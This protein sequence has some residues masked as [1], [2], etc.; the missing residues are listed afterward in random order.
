M[1]SPN[2]S[3][4]SGPVAY[5]QGGRCFMCRRGPQPVVTIFAGSTTSS[6]VCRR[7]IETKMIGLIEEMSVLLKL[8]RTGR[9]LAAPPPLSEYWLERRD[10]EEI[11]G[12][13][14]GARFEGDRVG[15]DTIQ[16]FAPLDEGALLSLV[17][18]EWESEW[19]DRD[20]A[21]GR[22]RIRRVLPSQ[23]FATRRYWVETPEDVVD[24]VTWL[25]YQV[26]QPG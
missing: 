18:M 13:A 11:V 6:A 20:P 21:T 5:Q 14:R 23:L 2:A 10:T 17:I 3:M 12:F 15:L 25:K 9:P 16:I 4:V 22:H 7:C 8:P 24:E 26:P 1:K 19:A